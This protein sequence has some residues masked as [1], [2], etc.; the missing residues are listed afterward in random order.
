MR[1]QSIVRARLRSRIL[2][3][4]PATIAILFFAHTDLQAQTNPAEP[5]NAAPRTPALLTNAADVLSLSADEA[6]RNIPV[7][8]RGVVTETEPTWGGQF[9]IQDDTSGVF[10]ES[11]SDEHPVPGDVVEVKGVS[12]P[13][14]YAPIISQPTWTIVGTAPLPKARRV[15]VDQ[16][17]SGLEDGQR[18][19]IDG[20]VRAVTPSDANLDLE[21]VS[22]GNRI[23]IYPKRPPGIDPQSLVGA[24]VRARGTLAASFNA[25][26]RHLVS[27]VL[28]VPTTND[29]IIE[30]MEATN[31]FDKPIIPLSGTAEYR[32]DIKPGRRVHVKGIVTLQRPGQD[33]FLHD[34]SGGLHVETRQPGKLVVGQVVDVVGFPD[35]DHFLPVLNDATFRKTTETRSSIEPT[36]VSISDITR[37]LH[38]ADLITLQTNKLLE[39]TVRLSQVKSRVSVI[40]LL[41]QSED[42][43]SEHLV[44][45]AEAEVPESD[46][47]L[48]AIPLGSL[49]EATG[50]CFTQSGEDKKLH[51]LQL[52]LADSNSVRIL[53][54][55]SWFTPQHLRVGFAILFAVLMVALGWSIMV[56]KRNSV[57]H[58][59]IREREAGQLAL[60]EA[61]DQLE[62]RVKERTAQLK[63]QISARK[64]SELQ[65][66]ATLKERTRLAQELHDTL[67]QTLTGIA[68]Q[69]DTTS[70]L[71]EARPEGASRHLELARS[72]VSQSQ[73]DV[74]RSVW[75]LRSRA[76]EQFDLPEALS[77]SGKQL[78]DGT[79]IH[80]K[81]FAKGRVRPLSETVEENLLR[82]AQE[83]LTNVIKHSEATTATIELDYG[84]QHIVLQ[85]TDNGHGFD[86]ERSAGP[87]QGHFGLLGIS[88][89][90]KR[91]GAELAISSEPG[92][93]TTVRIRVPIDQ[94]SP[95]PD[96]ATP[97]AVI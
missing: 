95:A 89:R 97:E 26:L 20:I 73:V 56:L 8:V 55:P 45:T 5:T 75:D 22:G 52:L 2:R 53:Q 80:L 30:Q 39:R 44:F 28:F 88:E 32:R 34:A 87:S 13:G 11:R 92:R 31:P 54:K 74:R 1:W 70:K 21:V 71:F 4:F 37:G 63:F 46:D 36:N 47:R 24:R 64:E 9:F 84:P 62:E 3:F 23:R 29:F 96:F 40:T 78:T 68:L 76:L 83:A 19:E 48:A 82:I 41:L 25:A 59:L 27:V 58:E 15:P 81:V 61:H 14:A 38:H 51:S 42:P 93:G 69:L 67:E 60:Q 79:K 17:M 94:N 77:T 18:V 66:K 43:Q 72:L 6:R 65:F 50:I 12:Q 7:Q 33:L 16:L 86:Q 90:A 85:I 35:F 91:L 57:L 10:V 49:V